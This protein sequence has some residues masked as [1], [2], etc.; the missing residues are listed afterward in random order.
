[1]GT[2]RSPRR[3]LLS[4]HLECITGIGR[5][6]HGTATRTI[7]GTRADGTPWRLSE[8]DAISGIEDCRWTLHVEAPAGERVPVVI[9]LRAGKKFLT[10]QLDEQM[11]DLLLGLPECPP[12]KLDL[13]SPS[14]DAS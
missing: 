10:A 4:F 6:L 13:G 9:A 3:S 11:P 14:R 2:K 5:G 8:G 1:M 7:G 12:V